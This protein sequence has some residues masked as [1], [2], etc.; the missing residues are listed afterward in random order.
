MSIDLNGGAQPAPSFSNSP[1]LQELEQLRAYRQETQSFLECLSPHADDIRGIVEDENF[2]DRVRRLRTD[3]RARQVYDDSMGAY[4]TI[5]EKQ[6]PKLSRE[7]DPEFNPYVKRIDDMAKV[8]D[9]FS[10]RAD[11]YE[12]HER[13]QANQRLLQDNA[14]IAENLIK[15][16]PVLAENGHAGIEAIAIRSMQRSISFEEAARQLEPLYKAQTR[17]SIDEPTLRSGA[18]MQGVPGPSSANKDVSVRERF[19][20]IMDKA[21]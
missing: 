8:V 16:Y 4:D 6:K 15:D 14:K 18:G 2:R 9:K 13:E 21:R 12:R 10:Q 19:L 11:E 17:A 20:Q 3:E 1:D 5:I 7:W